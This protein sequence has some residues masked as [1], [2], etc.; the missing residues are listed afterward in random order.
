MSTFKKFTIT[1]TLKR[2][3]QDGTGVTERLRNI[4]S[5]ALNLA[6]E[7]GYNENLEMM[8]PDGKFIA[9][10]DIS[11]MIAHT[12]SKERTIK[13]ESEFVNLLKSHKINPALIMNTKIRSKLQ[14]EPTATVEEAANDQDIFG[15]SEPLETIQNEPAINAANETV[16]VSRPEPFH[17]TPISETLPPI[18]LTTEPEAV[19]RKSPAKVPTRPVTR[20][21]SS[22][23]SAV[24]TRPSTRGAVSKTL[25]TVSRP[26]SKKPIT[27]PGGKSVI[28][29][30]KGKGI[31]D[32]ESASD[33]DG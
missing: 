33:S 13:G 9:G 6:R 24:A 23:T 32:W 20:G 8:G 1:P 26:V 19:K 27:G 18:E 14:G 12:M 16:L 15:P 31:I 17:S 21:I 7:G 11:G 28:P 2:N 4:L 10:S 3:H 22:K 5:L 29:A 25:A 30:K